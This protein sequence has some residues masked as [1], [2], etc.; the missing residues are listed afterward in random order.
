MHGD[1]IPSTNDADLKYPDTDNQP[2][3]SRS[4]LHLQNANSRF[5]SSEMISDSSRKLATPPPS[6]PSATLSKPSTAPTS[7]RISI[8]ADETTLPLTTSKSLMDRMKERHRLEV[9]RSLNTSPFSGNAQASRSNLSSPSMPII[10][11]SPTADHQSSHFNNNGSGGIHQ[12]QRSLVQSHSFSTYVKPPDSPSASPKHQSGHLTRSKSI[13]NDIY[14]K[15][16]I[17]PITSTSNIITG[18]NPIQ[19]KVLNYL[20]Y[21]MNLDLLIQMCHFLE[22]V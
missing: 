15:S 20:A 3:R 6:L 4:A 16:S 18:S 21:F 14:G 19:V 9:R 11:S 1:S 12:P 17:K 13:A 2:S 22:T 7:N 8:L 5:T 10:F